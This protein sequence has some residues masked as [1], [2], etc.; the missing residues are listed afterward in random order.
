MRRARGTF[1]PIPSPEEAASY[2]F[3]EDERE[4]VADF[5][6]KMFVGGPATVRR[7]LEAFAAETGA[8]ELMVNTMVW[9]HEARKRSYTLLAEAFGLT[10]APAPWPLAA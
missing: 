3:S 7:R 4:F 8:D 1:A 9:D 2:P 6:E 10:A 5:R